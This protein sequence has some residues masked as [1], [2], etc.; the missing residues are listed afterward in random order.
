MAGDS[1]D[2]ILQ[3]CGAKRAATVIFRLPSGP[4]K[5][6]PHLLYILFLAITISGSLGSTVT[7]LHLDV[8]VEARDGTGSR[9]Q[10]GRSG[11]EKV[12]YLVAAG[13][14]AECG[15]P[16][17]RETAALLK[18][19]PGTV[20][21]LGD[22]AYEQGSR[23]EFANCYDPTWGEEK[24]RTKPAVGNHEYETRGARGYFG[25]FGD[26]AGSKQTGYY[27]YDLGSW[28][29]IVLNSNC[30]DAGGCEAASSQGRWLRADLDANPAICTL[31]YWHH[32]LFS[33]GKVHGGDVAM[34]EFWTLLYDAGADI[35][36]A[37]HE[38]NYER[39][40]P[41]DPDG[42]RDPRKGIR[43]FVV[44]TGGASLY[45]FGEP[46]PLSEARNANTFGVLALTLR[47]KRYDWEFMPVTGGARGT[48]RTPFTDAGSGRCH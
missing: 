35:V 9:S 27:S 42:E 12:A 44:G 38:H 45:L 8:R 28:H 17:A 15:A 40:A 21:T 5:R 25:Y 18:R 1:S 30:D 31:A 47:P 33:S 46:M 14:I 24:R 4:V 6:P 19:L 11:G 43:E 41:Q 20:A 32:P 3:T 23:D 29:I 37:G 7:R 13:D 2:R 26:A 22:N 48:M 36:L 16:H 34:R 10:F 39:F